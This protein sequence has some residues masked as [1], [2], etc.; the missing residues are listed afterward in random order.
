M[1]GA[2]AGGSAAGCALNRRLPR[3]LHSIFSGGPH[4]ISDL[5]PGRHRHLH[6]PLPAADAA[7]VRHLFCG[8]RAAHGAAHAGLRGR[9]RARLYG[10][11][12]GDGRAGRDGGQLPDPLAD[13]RQHRVR[14]GRGRVRAGLPRRA[15]AGS[16]PRAA[17]RRPNRRPQL[18][19]VVF[20]RRR[21]LGRLDALRRRVSRFGADA[22]LAAG[23]RR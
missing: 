7:G 5:V 21:V 12:R 3:R 10:A 22:G 14:A 17:P 15:A 20:V 1:R 8:R 4:A 13:R 23:A 16:V 11:V 2:R 18:L 19:F 9:V 6:L